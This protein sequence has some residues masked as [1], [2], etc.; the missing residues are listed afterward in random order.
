[1]NR[2]AR[3]VRLLGAAFALGAAL[4][5]ARTPAAAPA[6]APKLA[7]VIAVDGLSMPRLLSYRAWFVAG[8]K[9]LLDE[10][11]VET[12][13]TYRHIN[14]ETGP[15]HASLGTG[16][17]P[18]VHG[19]VINSWF[20][21]RRGKG[22][23]SVYCT[24]QP[25]PSS[26]AGSTLTISGPANLRVPT[27]GDALV[28]QKEGARVVSISGKDRAAIFLAGRSPQHAVYWYDKSNGTFTTSAAFDTR[29]GGAAVASVVERFNRE[30][31]GAALRARLGTAWT[32]LA[33][34]PSPEGPLPTPVPPAVLQRFQAPSVG[35][36]WAKDLST[37]VPWSREEPSGYFAGVYRSPVVDQLTADLVLDVLADPSVALGRRAAPDLLAVSFSGNDPVSHDYG[38]ESEEALETLRRLDVQIGRL[39]AALEKEFPK[40]SVL[41][42][43][44]ADHGFNPIPEAAR[45]LD[46][47][48]PGGRV[49]GS[50]AYTDNVVD[51]LNRMLADELC[52]DRSVR[53]I[54]GIEGWS[55]FY[56]RTAFPIR[57]VEGTCGAAGRALTPADVDRV[58]PKLVKLGYDEVVAG[59]L[60]VGQMTSWPTDDPAVEFVRNDFDAER[61]GDAF[62][63]PRPG[64]LTISDPGRG[65]MHGTHYDADTHVPLVFWGGPAGPGTSAAPATP[66]DLAPT[67]AAWLGVTV[68]DATGRVLPLGK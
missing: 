36:G 53:P 24:D 25:D 6:T 16:A 23:V 41:V 67:V 37:Y 44:S 50:R 38:S 46:R 66:Y 26:P 5:L 51:R 35:F 17:P 18:R 68:P 39:L 55:L 47:N 54:F 42:A 40:G 48:A 33:P 56:R 32:K 34:P 15:G 31:G 27:L 43:F 62:L 1:M 30:K 9:R 2:L 65:S 4:L 11:Q 20:E 21:A 28:A 19:I 49:V 57:S 7:V 63:I 10:G 12:N 45:A 60:P 52:F 61:S 29:G 22:L 64:V 59:V 13:A 58:L 3:P 14:T 8:L